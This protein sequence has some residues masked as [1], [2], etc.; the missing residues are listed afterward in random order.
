M[1]TNKESIPKVVSNIFDKER[2]I[3]L[4]EYFKSHPQL[5]SLEYDHYGSKRI[6]S[7]DDPV[8]FQ[9]LKDLTEF[10][11]YHFNKKDI[12]HTYGIFAEYSGTG[13]Q[14][15]EHKDVGPCTYTIDIEI[16]HET[17]WDLIIEG[18]RYKF[19][20]NEAV[21]FLANDQDHWKEEFPNPE[22]NKVG[23]LLLHWVDS[24]HPWLSL[25]ESVQKLLR[26][27]VKAI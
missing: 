11:K 6:D 1:S 13:A 12:V 20:E 24:N 10:A 8:I 14:L 21:L 5:N 3:Y 9:C 2:F 18:K 25:P 27:R 23:I 22:T 17:P 16:Y 4:Q 7:F 19:N 26:K 15:E